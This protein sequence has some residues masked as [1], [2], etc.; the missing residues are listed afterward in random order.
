ME[1]CIFC[2][3]EATS[4]ILKFILNTVFE[5]KCISFPKDGETLEYLHKVHCVKTYKQVP[6]SILKNVPN[7]I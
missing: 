4:L 5:I 6:C 7:N 2:Q 3:I 1:K